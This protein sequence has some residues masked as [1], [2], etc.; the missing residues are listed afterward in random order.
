[1]SLK[2]VVGQRKSMLFPKFS[3]CLIEFL[4]DLRFP[5]CSLGIMQDVIRVNKKPNEWKVSW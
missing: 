3:V 2:A 5:V 4:L 1:M